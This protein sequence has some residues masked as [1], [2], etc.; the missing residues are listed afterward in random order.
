MI[1]FRFKPYG[2]M[3]KQMI[4]DLEALVGKTEYKVRLERRDKL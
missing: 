1:L 4:W 3:P 2:D